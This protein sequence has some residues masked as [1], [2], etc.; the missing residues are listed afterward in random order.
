MKTLDL[1]VQMQTQSAQNHDALVRTVNEGFERIT[2]V[3]TS[4][5]LDD[6]KQFGELDRRLAP[7]ES[8]RRSVR[9]AAGAICLQFIVFVFGLVAYALHR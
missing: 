4:H 1:L 2:A 5:V 8:M 7:V 3:M 9:W 6:V